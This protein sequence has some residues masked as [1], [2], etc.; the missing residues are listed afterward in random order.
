MVA[1]RALDVRDERLKR[2]DGFCVGSLD[3]HRDWWPLG[4]GGGG[5]VV[6]KPGFGDM[7]QCTRESGRGNREVRFPD[8]VSGETVV[9]ALVGVLYWEGFDPGETVSDGEIVALFDATKT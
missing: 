9:A 3:E 8:G 5:N 7:L 6:V 2:L 4:G 1:A